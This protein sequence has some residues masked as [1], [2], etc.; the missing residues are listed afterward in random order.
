MDKVFGICGVCCLL[1]LVFGLW[2][3][4]IVFYM[5]LLGGCMM[6]WMIDLGFVLLIE[7]VVFVYLWVC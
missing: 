6:K 1:I 3:W 2:I 5:K 7:D 4:G